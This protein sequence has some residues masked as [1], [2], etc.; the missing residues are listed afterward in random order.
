MQYSKL[1]VGTIIEFKGEKY[2]AVPNLP[3]YS[4]G[5]D[6]IYTPIAVAYSLTTGKKI[7]TTNVSKAEISSQQLP[8]EKQ[9]TFLV[10][11]KMMGIIDTIPEVGKGY[12]SIANV[13]IFQGNMAVIPQ[14]LEVENDLITVFIH[15]KDKEYKA[16]V[17]QSGDDYYII[18]WR[19]AVICTDLI[20]G[21]VISLKNLKLV[22]DER[23]IN[24]ADITLAK[25]TKYFKKKYIKLKEEKNFTE[26]K[27]GYYGLCCT[28]P[29]TVS[30]VITPEFQ[31]TFRTETRYEYYYN[32]TL[33]YAQDIDTTISRERTLKKQLAANISSMLY[34][35]EDILEKIQ[36]DFPEIQVKF[37]NTPN[38]MYSAIKHTLTT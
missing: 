32:G 33:V 27:Y 13:N 17:K 16:K 25:L 26:D 23:K 1:K 5:N 2:L 38:L 24:V 35:G 29:E 14:G 36:K 30:R 20:K 12:D 18:N 7:G 19:E 9:N 11:L 31:Y 8:L 37:L 10:K 34:T 15:Y 4:K 6:Y 3:T 28:P 22:T 21:S